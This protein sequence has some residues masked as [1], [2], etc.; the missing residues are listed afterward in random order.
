MINWDKNIVA[1]IA[2]RKC[3][4][5]LGAGISKN[6]RNND[7]QAPKDWK[8]FL[9]YSAALIAKGKNKTRINNLIK[10]CDY[11]TACE[12]IK[13]SLGRDEFCD[14]LKR[15]FLTPRFKYAEIHEDIFLLDSRI[16]ITPNFDKIYDLYAEKETQGTVITKAFYDEDIA[17]CIRSEERLILKIHGTIST[18]DKVIFTR[19]D[20]AKARIKNKDFYRILDVLIVTHTF[21]F[22]GAGMNDPDIRLLLEDYAFRFEYKKKHILFYLKVP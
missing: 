13:N 17:D 22:I 5:V 7:G 14:L 9:E 4:L 19:N 15:E 20:Y 1:D 3:V 11:L 10:S 2:R 21:I 18:P 12:L 16:I 8:E 6:S